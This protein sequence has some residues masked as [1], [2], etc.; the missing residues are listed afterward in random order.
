MHHAIRVCDLFFA[1]AFSYSSI[2]FSGWFACVINQC[3]YFTLFVVN[4]KPNAFL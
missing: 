4:S 3:N 1:V 2:L